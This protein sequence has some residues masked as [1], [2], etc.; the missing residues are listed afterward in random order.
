M[1]WPAPHPR[2]GQ[3]G[4]YCPRHPRGRILRQGGADTAG[5]DDR[6]RRQGSASVGKSA[7]GLRKSSAT[8]DAENNATELE[9]QAKYGWL[10]NTQSAVYTMAAD[11]EKMARSLAQK[12]N[13]YSLT[14]NPVRE[15]GEKTKQ[16][17]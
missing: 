11:R 8:R 15:F 6:I 14:Q 12:T 5:R 16:K 2:Q 3:T 1:R 13:G 9:L 17:Q 10:T 4:R 7:H